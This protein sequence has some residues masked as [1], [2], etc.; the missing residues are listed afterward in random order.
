MTVLMS[1]ELEAPLRMVAVI[2]CGVFAGAA[3]Y[4]NL[5]EHP[6]RIEGGTVL[7]LTEWVPSYRRATAGYDQPIGEQDLQRVSTLG[8]RVLQHLQALNML[9]IELPNQSFPALRSSAN[10]LFVEAS[11]QFCETG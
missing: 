6:A 4:I 8:G 2:C 1:F 11:G 10:V 3:I 9:V 7:A 5:V